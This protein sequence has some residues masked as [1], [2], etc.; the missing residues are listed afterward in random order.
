MIRIPI[1]KSGAGDPARH[2]PALLSFALSIIFILLVIV[3]AS[4]VSPTAEPGVVT[5]SAVIPASAQ[6]DPVFQFR[7]G[8][9]ITLTGTNTGSRTTYLFLAGPNLNESG[10]QI[11]SDYPAGTPVIEGNASTFAKA[12]VGSDGGWTYIWDTAKSSLASG[13]YTIYAVSKPHDKAHLEYSPYGSTSVVLVKPGSPQATRQEKFVLEE[14]V[15]V[16]PRGPVTSATPVTMTSVI[17]FVL[18]GS[19]TT[20]PSDHDL[21]FSTTLDNPQWS[22]TLVL[23]GVGNKRPVMPGTVLDLSGFELSYPGNINEERLMVTLEGTAPVVREGRTKKVVQISMVDNDGNVVPNSTVTREIA[24]LPL[25]GA[26]PDQPTL[27]PT[28][29]PL[30]HR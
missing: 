30:M 28:T 13:A 15:G 26:T 6:G 27:T 7:N 16:S 23:D 12:A 4:A 17:D 29:A 10:A 14:M 21:V 19:E 25:S 22:Y 2:A 11:Q 5:I 24:V 20:F 9:M 1:K 3:P 8:D 18:T